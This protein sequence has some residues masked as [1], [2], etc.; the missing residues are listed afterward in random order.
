MSSCFWYSCYVLHRITVL[1]DSYKKNQMSMSWSWWYW[2]V[3]DILTSSEL[4][5]NSLF[6]VIWSSLKLLT[7]SN[8]WCF[9]FQVKI[10]SYCIATCHSVLTVSLVFLCIYFEWFACMSYH[11]CATI[12][13]QELRNCVV[14]E[15]NWVL[16]NLLNLCIVY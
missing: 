13:N 11:R 9:W 2:S 4:Y 15:K 6:K 14:Q 7:F 8:R 1:L 5:E 12:S 3:I 16:L 10:S